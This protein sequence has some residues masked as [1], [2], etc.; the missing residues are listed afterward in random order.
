ME[1]SEVI[2][3]EEMFGDPNDVAS[4][5]EMP[6]TPQP[7]GDIISSDEMFGGV[8]SSA[9][10][11]M[12]QEQINQAQTEQFE[13]EYEQSYESRRKQTDVIKGLPKGEQVPAVFQ[14]SPIH[15]LESIAQLNPIADRSARQKMVKMA[16]AKGIPL[17]VVNEYVQAENKDTGLMGM[18]KKEAVPTGFEV[19]GGIVGALG[20]K[21]IKGAMAGRAIGETVQRVGERVLY[22]ER[23]K[24]IAQDIKEGGFETGVAGL[25]EWASGKIVKAGATLL[26]PAGKSRIAGA[27]GM[28]DVIQKAG[29][30]VTPTDVPE[31]AIGLVSIKDGGV[32]LTKP[33]IMTPGQL[34]NS[35]FFGTMDNVS[36]K[37]ITSMQRVAEGK[38]RTLVAYNKAAGNVLE[39]FADDLATKLKPSQVGA[40]LDDVINGDGGAMEAARGIYRQF[41]TQLDD[42]GVG[43]VSNKGAKNIADDLLEQVSKG[44]LLKGSDEGAAFVKSVSELADTSTFQQAITNRSQLFELARK[45]DS[46]GDRSAARIARQLGDSLDIAMESAARGHSEVAEKLWRRGNKTFKAV[47]KRFDDVVISRLAKEAS[48]SPELAAKTIFKNEQPTRILK[49]KKILLSTSGKTPKQ[50]AEGKETWGQLKN[51]FVE[52]LYKKSRSKGDRMIFGKTLQ[53]AL[54]DFGDEAMKAT[55]TPKQIKDLNKIANLGARVQGKIKGEGGMFIQLAQPAAVA[56]AVAGEGKG[57]LAA[58]ALLATPPVWSRMALNPKTSKYLINGL[59]DIDKQGIHASTAATQKL[60]RVYF[61]ERDKYMREQ[62]KAKARV[63]REEWAESMERVPPLPHGIGKL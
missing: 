56:G 25:G 57:R 17:S 60:L 47:H 2:S 16:Q 15:L 34:T 40:L 44:G 51:V 53:N 33:A 19:A 29:E 3:T 59:V 37:A 39:T 30:G 8:E 45:F 21:P 49:V 12:T 5:S 61:T 13:I 7:G 10:A 46:A 6:D 4:S 31:S 50:I 38:A 36:E 58:I 26:K 9:G 41:Y 32:G 14:M 11:P 24:T 22:P 28:Q 62:S 48:S 43:S 23:Q 42:L 52:S 1:S 54:H 55:F 35:R 63:K 20:K 18:V 27:Q